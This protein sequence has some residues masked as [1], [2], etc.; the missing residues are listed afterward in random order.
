MNCNEGRIGAAARV[1]VVGLIEPPEAGFEKQFVG[2]WMWEKERQW[3]Q[4]HCLQNK[5]LSST[6]PIKSSI[7]IIIKSKPKTTHTCY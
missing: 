1:E 7:I 4:S 6:L 3:L 5:L 2:A